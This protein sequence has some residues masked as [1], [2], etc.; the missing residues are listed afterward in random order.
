ME[1]DV[2][3]PRETV[4]L[5][6]VTLGVDNMGA[7]FLESLVCSHPQLGLLSLPP[8]PAPVTVE[9]A[10]PAFSHPPGSLVRRPQ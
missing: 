10:L 4:S 1:D 5:T 6:P 2:Q 8:P 3:R 9:G 7:E